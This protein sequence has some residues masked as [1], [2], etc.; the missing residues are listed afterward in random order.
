MNRS[1]SLM[2]KEFLDRHYL[3]QKP[4]LLGYSGGPDSK[5]LLYA[6]LE[7]GK[8]L[9]LHIA[10]V[11]H[12]WR[13]E[14]ADEA[15]LLKEEAERLDLPFHHCRLDLKEHKNIEA[16]CREKRLLFFSE[17]LEKIKGDALLL[18]H[19]KND[20]SETVLKRLFEGAH[21]PHL[22]GLREVANL[23]GMQVWRPMLSIVKEEIYQFLKERGLSWIE[24]PTNHANH[25]L[26]G[27]MR[28]SLIPLLEEHFGKEIQENLYLLGKRS[29]ELNGYLQA[30]IA[31]LL[32]LIKTGPFGKWLDLTIP[33]HPFERRHLLL[34]FLGFTPKRGDLE[35]MLL[36]IEQKEPD[37]EWGKFFFD[38]GFIFS[39]EKPISFPD[40]WEI[41]IDK[42]S[43]NE[44]KNSSWIDFL[45]GRVELILPE[46]DYHFKP[47]GKEYGA[48]KKL[49]SE[50]DVPVFLREK[51]PI[52][53]R[54]NEPY[55][56][57]L[58]GIEQKNLKHSSYLHI[59]LNCK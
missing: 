26:R 19:Q 53:F 2:V 13:E 33:L 21:L 25:L 52:V 56:E 47:P 23:Q 42:T 35:Q 58:T 16:I 7:C 59:I 30:R 10:H 20:V 3:S 43:Q 11:D 9:P 12:G 29:E 28:S 5:A 31:P 38:R 34:Q 39:I 4:L 17:V 37:K 49:W 41:K 24:D 15:Q 40:G 6:L 14:S 50:H 45:L 54:G 57:L 51:L 1:L 18:A 32:E 36:W 44:T 27:R 48:F 8:D 55:Q 46:G 22:Y